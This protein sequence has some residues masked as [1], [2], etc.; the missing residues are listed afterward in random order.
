[1]AGCF[2]FPSLSPYNV[3]ENTEKERRA[4]KRPLISERRL[5]SRDAAEIK[6]VS[7]ASV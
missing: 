7:P 3:V 1:M 6:T 4:L 5:W 2:I